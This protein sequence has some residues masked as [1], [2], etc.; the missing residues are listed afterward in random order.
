MQAL[1]VGEPYTSYPPGRQRSDTDADTATHRAV[2][3]MKYH[4]G[5]VSALVLPLPAS[6]WTQSSVVPQ[7]A[8]TKVAHIGRHRCRTKCRPLQPLHMTSQA[9][10][11]ASGLGAND[12]YLQPEVPPTE[13]QSTPTMP[14]FDRTNLGLHVKLGS[15]VMNL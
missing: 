15:K 2:W 11:L 3:T 1:R 12:G 9:V 13:A 5:C 8:S 4:M 14:V 7:S 10:N 6:A